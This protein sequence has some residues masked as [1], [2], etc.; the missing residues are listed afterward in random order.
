MRHLMINYVDRTH[1]ELSYTDM[2]E[3]FVAGI[4]IGKSGNADNVYV[5]RIPFDASPIEVLYPMPM[6]EPL[7]TP[8][9][10]PEPEPMPPEAGP[11]IR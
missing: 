6:V 9:P 5:F 11:A 10:T 1:T 3:A 2:M 8:E 4:G 7:P